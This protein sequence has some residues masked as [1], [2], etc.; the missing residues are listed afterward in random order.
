[1]KTYEEEFKELQDIYRREKF[2]NKY[3]KQGLS[4]L[5]TQLRKSVS[6]L[7][8]KHRE[9]KKLGSSGLNI[10]KARHR[11]E[12]LAVKRNFED[13]YRKITEAYTDYCLRM[14]ELKKQH[15]GELAVIRFNH[16]VEL[17]TLRGID[18]DKY[19]P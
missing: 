6:E 19:I 3:D 2:S 12:L 17:E 16:L 1:M 9:M 13:E 14:A 4:E 11:E 15:E 5:L 10:V 18:P 8:A 7:A